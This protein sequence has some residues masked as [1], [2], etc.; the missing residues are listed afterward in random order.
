MHRMVR[1]DPQV[2]T[3]GIILNSNQRDYRT[4]SLPQRYPL[5]TALTPM[6]DAADPIYEGS[7][8]L[9]RGTLF[10]GL[11]LPFMDLVNP[12]LP[13]TPQT[14]IMAIDFVT[15]ELGLYLD[16]HADDEEAFSLYQS[17]LAMQQEA[18]RRYNE[19]CGPLMKRD[20]LGA[21]RYSWL[22][23]PWP[24]TYTGRKEK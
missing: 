3:G 6:Q 13:E 2:K 8:A 12:D 22:N 18:H 9:S 21:D 7:E 17:F 10:P 14:E 19:M 20:M 4:G 24:W 11:D 1:E 16:T 15:H 5:A 23:D